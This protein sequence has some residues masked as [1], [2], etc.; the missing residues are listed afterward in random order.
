LKHLHNLRDEVLRW[1]TRE[2][3]VEAVF[4][5]GSVV[6]GDATPASDLDVVIVHGAASDANDIVASLSKHFGERLRFAAH[7]NGDASLWVDAS[8]TKIDL[9]MGADPECFAWL[10]NSPDAPVPRLSVGLDK[11]GGCGELVTRASRVIA[12][13]RVR[14]CNDEIDKFITG[15]E[16]ASAA[17]RRSDGYQFYFHYNLALHRLARLI[18]LLRGDAAYLFLPKL[19]LSRRM[20]LPEQQKWRGLRGTMYLPEANA[21][22]RQLAETFVSILR[23]LMTVIPIARSP[24][25]IAS[26][27]NAVIQRD[28]FFNVRDFADSYDGKVKS[29]RLYRASSL[30]RW[31]DEPL[32][33]RWLADTGIRTIIDLRH[34]AEMT[35][36]KAQYPSELL[37][38]I[39]YVNFPLS[40]PPLPD[41]TPAPAEFGRVYYALLQEH[42]FAVA[43]ALRTLAM[44]DAGPT[45]VHC[46]VGKDRT[47]LFCA[48]VALLLEMPRE[49]IHADYMLSGQGVAE[50]A[51]RDYVD[52]VE[53]AGG[54]ERVLA[55]AGLDRTTVI[56]LR[57]HLLT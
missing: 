17:H 8:L 50:K 35:E 38:G 13:D 53:G 10:A 9:H 57:R 37:S 51:I 45:V 31:Q 33:S 40:G 44:P 7:T 36:A 16:A 20:P 4:W 54:A 14:L 12:R 34:P 28:L 52:A 24:D 49:S 32:L 47:G 22:K 2:P 6:R 15:F 48:L 43:E 1:A 30:T 39:R 23:E 42:L 26:F 11:T 21:A 29:G 18:E 19:L 55:S 5:H 25:V 41:R 27:L 3:L 46:H 56:A